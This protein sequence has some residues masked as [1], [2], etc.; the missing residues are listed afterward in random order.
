MGTLKDQIEEL[1]HLCACGYGDADSLD[2]NAAKETFGMMEEKIK[3]LKDFLGAIEKKWREESAKRYAVAK[4]AARTCDSSEYWQEII[5]DAFDDC[6]NEIGILL[7]NDQGHPAGR[8]ETPP[9]P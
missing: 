4:D 3:S 8:G 6:A 5:G 7:H 9:K 1:E 2:T